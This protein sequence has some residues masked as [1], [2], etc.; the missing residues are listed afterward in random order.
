MGKSIHLQCRRCTW[1]GFNPWDGKIPW[2]RKWKPT[3][4]FL[5]GKSHGQSLMDYSPWG[6]KSRSIQTHSISYK[7]HLPPVISPDSYMNI[8]HPDP[9]PWL[10]LSIQT[11][12]TLWFPYLQICSR[13]I[14]WNSVCCQWTSLPVCVP[15]WFPSHH[16]STFLQPGSKSTRNRHNLMLKVSSLF[17][18]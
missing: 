9:L 1:H 12:Q 6:R 18:L 10:V 5:P 11:Q 8:S 2:R 17:P 16:Y 14:H 7:H 15:L 4:V 3:P 13:L